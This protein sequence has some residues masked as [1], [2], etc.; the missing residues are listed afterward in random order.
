MTPSPGVFLEDGWRSWCTLPVSSSAFG[1]VSEQGAAHPAGPGVG[2]PCPKQ[3][4]Q[5][6]H[7]AEIHSN[8]L[9]A[10][11]VQLK[12]SGLLLGVGKEVGEEESASFFS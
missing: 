11:N 7:M 6:L 8:G 3:Q 4:L 1:E 5:S 9:S 12:R 10:P 2:H